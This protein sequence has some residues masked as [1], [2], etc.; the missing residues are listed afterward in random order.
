MCEKEQKSEEQRLTGAEFIA[1]M[2][3]LLENAPKD[4]IFS[5][6]VLETWI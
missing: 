5:V 1:G 4:A 3:K 6:M 2:K